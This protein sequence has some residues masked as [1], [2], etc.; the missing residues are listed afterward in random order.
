MFG[1]EIDWKTARKILILNFGTDNPRRLKSLDSGIGYQIESSVIFSKVKT[2]NK[3]R[4]LLFGFDENIHAVKQAIEKHAIPQYNYPI[5]HGRDRIGVF[6]TDKGWN[7][8]DQ[9]ISAQ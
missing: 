5:L 9:K 3:N 4:Y 2:K 1:A 8:E 6:S 7:I